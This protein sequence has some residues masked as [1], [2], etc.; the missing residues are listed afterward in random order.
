MAIPRTI[1]NLRERR[2]Q[3]REQRAT[4][5]ARQAR[6]RVRQCPPRYE[7]SF[8]PLT[9]R[10]SG[11]SNL[12]YD[13]VS[14]PT[15]LWWEDYKNRQKTDFERQQEH[16]DYSTCKRC[17]LVSTH[18]LPTAAN[19]LAWASVCPKCDHELWDKWMG[20]P[21]V[22]M[23]ALARMLENDLRVSRTLVVDEDEMPLPEPERITYQGVP[24]YYD[25]EAP[26]HAIFANTGWVT[27]TNE[28]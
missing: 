19:T 24:Y 13:E 4:E 10:I 8:G 27:R 2:R 1:A 23:R 12:A 5:Q 26:R 9:G 11:G 20:G 3:E 7:Y 16:F 21:L 15:H 14:D 28:P 25:V 22:R 17:G 18:S 6:Q